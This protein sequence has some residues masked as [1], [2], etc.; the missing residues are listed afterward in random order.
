M[1][2]ELPE[3]IKKFIEFQSKHSNDDAFIANYVEQYFSKKKKT[4]HYE[5]DTF[6]DEIGLEYNS[7]KELSEQQLEELK[8]LREKYGKDE[9][10]EHLDELYPDEDDLFE[11][12]GG[13]EVTGMDL[14][15][16]Y[17]TYRFSYYELKG[18]VVIKGEAKVHLYDNDYKDL[19]YLCVTDTTM[20][21]NKLK[22]ADRKLHDSIMRQIENRF[23][24]DGFYKGEYPFLVTMDEAKH[25]ADSIANEHK[26]LYRSSC[27]YVMK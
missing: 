5:I 23:N 8:G 25:D 27:S 21:I 13:N 15:T 11:L 3:S 9:F 20:N 7:L 22:Y 6:N 14:D 4:P 17:Y 2:I 10:F 19:L 26:E 16:P 1:I 18:D 24:D 12:T